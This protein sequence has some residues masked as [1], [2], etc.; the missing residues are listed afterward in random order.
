MPQDAVAGYVATN[1]PNQHIEAKEVRWMLSA[2]L[3]RLAGEAIDIV[4]DRY[5][6]K[7]RDEALEAIFAEI[8]NTH[9]VQMQ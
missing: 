8:I 2:S 5:D 3:A 4:M 1:H 9:G 7:T 6:C